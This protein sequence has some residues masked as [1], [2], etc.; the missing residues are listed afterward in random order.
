MDGWMDG[1]KD[2]HIDLSHTLLIENNNVPVYW[3]LFI[4]D[5]HTHVC[6]CV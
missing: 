5:T 2:R 6:V 3:T 4:L 1:W